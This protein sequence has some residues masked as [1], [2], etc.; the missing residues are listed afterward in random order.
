MFLYPPFSYRHTVSGIYGGKEITPTADDGKLFLLALTLHFFV[1]VLIL[2]F[3]SL[4]VVVSL[5]TLLLVTF[6]LCRVG[7]TFFLPSNF[8]YVDVDVAMIM[9]RL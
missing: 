6:N 3:C 2:I 4:F 1:L 8:H 9:L 7:K 5:S